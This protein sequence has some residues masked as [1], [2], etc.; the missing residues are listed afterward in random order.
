MTFTQYSLLGECF[1]FDQTFCPKY[2]KMK[3]VAA[4]STMLYCNDQSELGLRAQSPKHKQNI[5]HHKFAPLESNMFP[6]LLEA[7]I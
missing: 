6:T 3:G 7:F 2:N 5:R 1:D 4:L